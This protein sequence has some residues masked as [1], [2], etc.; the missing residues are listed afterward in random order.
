MDGA[1]A[2]ELERHFQ[3]QFRELR[4]KVCTAEQQRCQ[5][6][7]KEGEEVPSWDTTLLLH[8]FPG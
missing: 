4:G 3:K 8:A 5:P 2:K 6:H 7:L 1:K